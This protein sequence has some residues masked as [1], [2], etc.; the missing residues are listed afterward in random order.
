MREIE[1]HCAIV[2]DNVKRNYSQD[3]QLSTN[4]YQSS[5]AY[6]HQHYLHIIGVSP[7]IMIP[8]SWYQWSYWGLLAVLSS[9]F[10]L[11]WTP[12]FPDD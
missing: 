11:S 5:M 3:I 7:I 12:F 8:V 10:Y 6:A 2:Q 4:H 9:L 1:Q